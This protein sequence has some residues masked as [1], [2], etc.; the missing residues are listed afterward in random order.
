MMDS[1]VVNCRAVNCEPNGFRVYISRNNTLMN[2]IAEH[3]QAGM[4]VES[5]FNIRLIGNQTFNNREF[6]FLFE[7]S[8]YNTLQGNMAFTNQWAGI[9][10]RSNSAKQHLTGNVARNNVLDGIFL[11]DTAHRKHRYDQ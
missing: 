8:D 4:F 5:S 2:N 9:A 6:G 7:N 10:I 11:N 1:T 3:G